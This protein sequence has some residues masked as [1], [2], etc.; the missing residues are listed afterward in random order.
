VEVNDEIV[1]SLIC[2][3][4]FLIVAG[5]AVYHESRSSKTIIYHNATVIDY[6]QGSFWKDAYL[7]LRLEDGTIVQVASKRLRVIPFN[8]SVN[9]Y[10]NG[11]VKALGAEK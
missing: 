2:L 3:S 5:I 4:V 8:V 6:D 1:I 9:V 11:R 10:K 7:T